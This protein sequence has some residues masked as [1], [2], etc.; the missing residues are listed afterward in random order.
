MTGAIMCEQ[1]KALDLEARK[2]TF[3]EKAP[4][5]IADEVFDILFGSVERL[6]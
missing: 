5:Q 6:R 4:R 2:S 1:V 3:V